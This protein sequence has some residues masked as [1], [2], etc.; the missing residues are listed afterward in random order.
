MFVLLTGPQCPESR[1]QGSHRSQCRLQW[2]DQHGIQ[3]W[4]VAPITSSPLHTDTLDVPG[5]RT[6]RPSRTINPFALSLALIRA[7]LT[8]PPV[9][10]SNEP[11]SRWTV[12][13]G[14]PL[15]ARSQLMSMSFQG[16]FVVSSQCF[17]RFWP[18]FCGLMFCLT[19]AVRYLLGFHHLLGFTFMNCPFF[20]LENQ[21]L[22][23]LRTRKPTYICLK[24]AVDNL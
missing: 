5:W 8:C 14:G 20:H 11:C 13:S 9:M 21:I 17:C 3:R 23:C 7:A 2:L 6:R 16:V 22:L 10:S 12:F 1:V 18:N 4:W 24:E 15:W 19:P